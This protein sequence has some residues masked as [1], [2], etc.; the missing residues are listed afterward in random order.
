MIRFFVAPEELSGQTARL[1]GENAR[2][3]KVLRLKQGEEVLLCDGGGEEWLCK[4][5]DPEEFCLSLVDHRPS[6]SEAAVRVSVYMAFPKA[7][8]HLLEKVGDFLFVA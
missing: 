2:H 5:E 3:A 8:K 1:T 4:V 6:S 7:D